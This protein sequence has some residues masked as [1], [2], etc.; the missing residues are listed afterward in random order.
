MQNWKERK[1]DMSMDFYEFIEQCKEDGL[2]PDEAIREWHK[3]EAEKRNRFYEEYYNDPVVCA[4]WSQQ[5]T[6]DLY[7][8]ER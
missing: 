7:R 2:S 6:I 4:G 3:A 8:R 5:D 1:M